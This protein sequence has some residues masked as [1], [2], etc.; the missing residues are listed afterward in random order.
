M[1]Q[2]TPRLCSPGLMKLL[3]VLL[4]IA[5]S[6][7]IVGPPLYWQVMEGLHSASCSP[8]VCDC[9]SEARLS[10]IPPGGQLHQ[11]SFC[12][13]QAAHP[14][15]LLAR[16]N[17][18]F[19]SPKTKAIISQTLKWLQSQGVNM[20]QLRLT[21]PSGFVSEASKA[22]EEKAEEGKDKAAKGPTSTPKNKFVNKRASGGEQGISEPTKGSTE[23]I[24]L[25]PQSPSLIPNISQPFLTSDTSIVATFIIQPQPSPSSPKCPPSQQSAAPTFSAQDSYS[26]TLLHVHLLH[27]FHLSPTRFPPFLF[28]RPLG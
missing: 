11:P 14:K 1:A 9:P 28:H 12:L 10:I 6:V 15:K 2:A 4:A 27:L 5:L 19:E 17:E 3:L 13:Q 8:C 24:I 21:M 16:S 18:G 25:D 23:T 7:Y 22:T 26:S 20:Q